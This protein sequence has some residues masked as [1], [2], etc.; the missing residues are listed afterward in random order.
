MPFLHD[1]S[2]FFRSDLNLIPSSRVLFDTAIEFALCAKTLSPKLC[3]WDSSSHNEH[4]SLDEFVKHTDR[5]SQCKQGSH[6]FSSAHTHCQV[7]Y[8]CL[9]AFSQSTHHQGAF[10][11]S[12][13]RYTTVCEQSCK[14]HD[15]ALFT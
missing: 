7:A 5:L 4:L 10:G 1:R 9:P 13:K 2:D 8:S 3:D 14:W 15:S 6:F 12:I 11:S